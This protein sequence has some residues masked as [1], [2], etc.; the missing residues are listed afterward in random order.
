M[1]L[2]LRILQILLLVVSLVAFF[3]PVSGRPYISTDEPSCI[4]S[5]APIALTPEPSVRVVRF[6]PRRS[7]GPDVVEHAVEGVPLHV[8][9]EV[10]GLLPPIRVYLDIVVNGR[11]VRREWDTVRN[12]SCTI[13]QPDP[14]PDGRQSYPV[15]FYVRA[16]DE[17]RKIAG[18]M[19]EFDVHRRYEVVP[20]SREPVVVCVN[21]G[22]PGER[23]GR[24]L[25]GPVAGGAGPLTL[26]TPAFDPADLKPRT[27]VTGP[28]HFDPLVV[29]DALGAGC[30]GG[31]AVS[32]TTDVPAGE[33][34]WIYQTETFNRY[35]GDVVEWSA[36][37]SPRIVGEVV[38][39]VPFPSYIE[40]DS[41]NDSK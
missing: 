8:H 40:S 2:R 7:G 3:L 41:P 16:S 11:D 35:T 36:D 34:R 19:V 14:V 5:A 25:R 38:A 22:N 30:S 18:G 26:T 15:R 39:E 17:F 33:S 12:Q 6:S 13:F 24:K 21:K 9:A 4:S 28:A 23:S 31:V 1:K 10:C 37:G 29:L 27:T 20:H 32:S